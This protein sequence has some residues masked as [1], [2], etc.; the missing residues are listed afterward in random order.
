MNKWGSTLFHLY[1][2]R[3]L[4]T[5]MYA[6]YDAVNDDLKFQTNTQNVCEEFAG[7]VVFSSFCFEIMQCKK[8]CTHWAHTAY[9]LTCYRGIISIMIKGNEFKFHTIV[10]VQ[11]R[12]KIP[13]FLVVFVVVTFVFQCAA[14]RAPCY[15]YSVCI[16]CVP[17]SVE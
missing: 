6:A 9:I 13:V 11:W 12:M 8:R 1:G 16:G 14:T 2:V 4:L 17:H 3:Y 7:V 15:L 10:K 5:T